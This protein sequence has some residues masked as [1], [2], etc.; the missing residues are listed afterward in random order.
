MTNIP[1]ICVASA[2]LAADLDRVWAAMGRGTDTFTAAMALHDPQDMENP[3]HYLMQDMSATEGLEALWRAFAASADLPPIDGIW[4]EEGVISAADAQA[5]SAGLTVYSVAAAS[6]SP[7]EGQSW[8]DGI[9]T[10][11]GLVP[12]PPPDI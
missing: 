1:C 10:S 9:I 6:I 7:A 12:A 5:A 3:T 2:A 4:G 8:R 11:L